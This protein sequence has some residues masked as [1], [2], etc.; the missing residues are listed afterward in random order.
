MTASR[1]KEKR[2]IPSARKDADEIMLMLEQVMVKVCEWS[3]RI[4]A[5]TMAIVERDIGA[6]KQRVVNCEDAIKQKVAAL[7]EA[8]KEQTKLRRAMEE[9]DTELEKVWVELETERRANT[10][11]E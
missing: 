8:E 9:R 6:W 10:D 5:Q 11:A 7:T 4:E 1:V 2:Q 3:K